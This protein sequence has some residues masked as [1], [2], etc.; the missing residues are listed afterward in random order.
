MRT[1]LLCAVLALWS[2]PAWS[3]DAGRPTGAHLLCNNFPPQKIENPAEGLDGFD[4][5]ILRVVFAR[6]GIEVKIDYYP[7]ARALALAGR[8]EADGLCSCSYLPE[9]E[10]A[11]Y[12]SIPMGE[13][14]IGIFSLAGDPAPARRLEDLRGR[15]VAV[16]QQYALRDVLARLGIESEAVVNETQ[17]MIMLQNGRVR[18][19]FTYRDPVLYLVQ[20]SSLFSAPQFAETSVSPYYACFAKR[21]RRGEALWRIFNQGLAEI[22]LTQADRGLRN[23]YFDPAMIERGAQALPSRP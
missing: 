3:Q 11:F 5:D 17:A 13:V 20:R 9:R 23:L 16:V 21:S 15:S 2:L 14:A 8:G 22:Q 4:V 18:H 12:F 19:F 1:F 6:A 7:W 10:E